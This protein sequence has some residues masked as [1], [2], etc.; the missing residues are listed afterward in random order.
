MYG[1]LTAE[2]LEAVRTIRGSARGLLELIDS[3]LVVAR[4]E[5]LKLEVR[6][7]PV[8]L[9]DVIGAVI[10]TGRL[11]VGSR[12]LEIESDVAADLPTVETDRQKL[13]QIL[14]NLLA[15]A[16]KFTPDEG[17]VHIEARRDGDHVVVSVSD[18]GIGIA[19]EALEKIFEP[20]TQAEALAV[21]EHGG[22]GLGLY[23]V[24]QLSAL[25]HID[26]AVDSEVGRG[27]TLTLRVPR[28]MSEVVA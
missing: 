3:L 27:S 13:V 11:V 2:Q 4:S 8:D 9:G 12:T 1:P 7:Q 6:A 21:R 19:P 23:V 28:T 16:I 18:T 25:L 20:F 14:V 22:A 15:N 24:R 26:V 10:A 5:A 17:R